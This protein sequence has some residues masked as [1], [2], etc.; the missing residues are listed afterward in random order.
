FGVLGQLFGFALD[1]EFERALALKIVLPP[2]A[3][4]LLPH[5]VE[6]SLGIDRSRVMV[7]KIAALGHQRHHQ[8]EACDIGRHPFDHGRVIL[9]DRLHVS[10]RGLWLDGDR[11]WRG[12][13]SKSRQA[14]RN[15]GKLKT[16]RRNQ[17]RPFHQWYPRWFVK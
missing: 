14:D 5:P 15:S 9:P 8:G 13:L 11:T 7:M 6:E 2:D 10:L 3:Q 4:P 16:D 12:V 1:G 17:E